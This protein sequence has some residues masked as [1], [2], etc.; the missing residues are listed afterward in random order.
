MGALAVSTWCAAMYP[1]TSEIDAATLRI[2]L[3]AVKAS[4]LQGV[5]ADMTAY[6]AVLVIACTVASAFIAYHHATSHRKSHRK[7][8]SAQPTPTA[9]P[10]APIADAD[11]AQYQ[12]VLATMPYSKKN[13]LTQEERKFWY[14][15]LEA[16]RGRG[17]SITI[18]PSLKEFIRVPDY[19]Q[20]EVSQ[21]AWREIA[22]KHVDFLVCDGKTMRPLYAIEYDGD[23]HDE[24]VAANSATIRNDRFKNLLFSKMEFP[25]I[26][27]SYGSWTAD[28]VRKLVDE[29]VARVEDEMLLEIARTL[30]HA[31]EI[32]QQSQGK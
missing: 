3:E 24:N 32:Q 9:T 12:A 25:L 18:K 15:L 20:G 1:D 13:L 19:D 11:E 8:I 29:K 10:S 2:V 14:V 22:Q 31:H 6:A 5:V 4:P 7:H 23:T 28:E 21:R 30:K 16:L 27:I 17:V 26:R